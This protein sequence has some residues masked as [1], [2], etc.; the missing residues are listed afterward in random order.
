LDYLPEHLCSIVNLAKLSSLPASWTHLLARVGDFKPS[1]Q[2]TPYSISSLSSLSL[3]L[4]GGESKKLERER[5]ET[6]EGKDKEEE[7][8]A[9]IKD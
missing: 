4:Q 2:T 5:G 8:K 7:I 9:K 3:S 6:R 1:G